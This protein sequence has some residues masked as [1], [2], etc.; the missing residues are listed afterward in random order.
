MTTMKTNNCK[1]N[2]LIGNDAG[3][4]P[5]S[6]TVQCWHWRQRNAGKDASAMPAEMPALHQGTAM[7]P[8]AT[9][10]QTAMTPRTPTYCN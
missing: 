4:M 1:D 2:I 10:R 5:A 8:R 9:T 6:A 7:K 3:T